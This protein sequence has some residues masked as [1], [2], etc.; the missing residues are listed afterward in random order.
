MNYIAI[1]ENVKRH[2]SLDESETDY[3]TSMLQYR[4]FKKKEIVLDKGKISNAIFVGSGCLRAYYLDETRYHIMQFAIDHWWIGDLKSFI[5]QTPSNLIVD[6]LIETEVFQISRQKTEALFT[7][8]PKFERFFRIQMENALVGQQDRIM[9]NLTLTA[10]MKYEKFV[11]S[12]PL[13]HQRI[14]LKDIANYLGITPE[15]LS[16]IRRNYQK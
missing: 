3:F 1:L 4:K 7:A 14:P 10:E 9:Q 12:Y 2:I 13:F 11:K 5:R 16:A 8:I 15:Y 6:A